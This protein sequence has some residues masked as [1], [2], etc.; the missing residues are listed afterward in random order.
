MSNARSERDHLC[1]AARLLGASPH[2][3]PMV[4]SSC[5]VTVAVAAAVLEFTSTSMG[6]K[7]RAAQQI[8]GQQKVYKYFKK[9]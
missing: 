3:S 8:P 1:E 7:K 9:A 5:L 6:G 4:R 2:L